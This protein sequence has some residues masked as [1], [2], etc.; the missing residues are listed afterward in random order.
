MVTRG[1]TI[2]RT[3]L[4]A[5]QTA[6]KGGVIALS[7]D[8]GDELAWVRL[9]DGDRELVVATRKGM[10]IRF[11]ESDV[12]PMGRTARGVRRSRLPRATR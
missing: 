3:E 4:S 6:R 12:R 7:L 5:F 2:K 11:S 1:G 10:A 8:E 9:T